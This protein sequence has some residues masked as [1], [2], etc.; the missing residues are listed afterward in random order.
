KRIGRR[1]ADRS[2]N[3][4]VGTAGGNRAGLSGEVRREENRHRRDGT[5][6][7]PLRGTLSPQAGRGA[8]RG[9]SL[10]A[11]RARRGA[12]RA[13]LFFATRVGRGTTHGGS[14]FATRARRGTTSDALPF[15]PLA[16]R[17]WPK[18]G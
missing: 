10:F 3:A 14:L 12:T 2:F 8:T 17:R 16:G 4:D 7:P 1:V 11:T 13:G 18:A 6:H 15:S 9:G 5:P